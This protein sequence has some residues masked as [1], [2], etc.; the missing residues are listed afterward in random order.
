MRG[1]GL[2]L[3]CLL[4]AGLLLGASD[5]QDPATLLERIR[6]HTRAALAQVEQCV[7]EQAIDRFHRTSSAQPWQKTDTVHLDVAL[8]ANEERYG[9]AGADR[10]FDRGLQESVGRGMTSTGRFGLIL[11]QVLDPSTTAYQYQPGAERNGLPAHQFEFEVLADKSRYHLRTA[12]A[13]KPVSYEG[14]LWA[15]QQSLDLI[16]LEAQAIDIPEELGIDEARF[17]V[18]YA[19]REIHADAPPLLLPV[20]I[21]V[22]LV[23]REGLQALNRARLGKCRLFAAESN[24]LLSGAET[25]ASA[26][27]SSR[28]SPPLPPGAILEIALEEPLHLDKVQPGQPVTA[29]L[30]R[31]VR[32]GDSLFLQEGAVVRGQVVGL[33][34]R[35]VPAP[36]YEVAITLSG[37]DTASGLHPI[38]A[39]LVGTDSAKGLLQQQRRLMPQF[40][41]RARN[42]GVDVLVRKV[43]QGHGILEWDPKHASIPRGFKTRWRLADQ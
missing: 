2:R 9:R 42:P 5:G 22:E 34:F 10:F 37:I 30:A 13:E 26:T 6:Q 41:Q 23:T 7:C 19:R 28:P 18:E 35:S 36:V 14:V 39:T 33:E 32:L 21:Q 4:P 17:H 25:P 43:E 8:S 31:P 27:P 29:R 3:G 12:S 38:S 16:R 20:Q 1:L 24:L 11:S 15:H 40:S